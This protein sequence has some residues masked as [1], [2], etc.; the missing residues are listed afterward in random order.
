MPNRAV[1]NPYL[2]GT[3]PPRSPRGQPNPGRGFP[4]RGGQQGRRTGRAGFIAREGQ[5]VPTTRPSRGRG[6]PRSLIRGQ[7]SLFGQNINPSRRPSLAQ[8]TQSQEERDEIVRQQEIHREQQRQ[9][10]ISGLELLVAEANQTR[11]S[12]PCGDLDDDD[13]SAHESDDED[14]DEDKDG[15][16]VDD[17][18]DAPINNPVH[19]PYASNNE[20]LSRRKYQY[21]P[22]K[23]STLYNYLNQ[24]KRNLLKNI[25]E[26]AELE[27]REG[28]GILRCSIHLAKP[29]TQSKRIGTEQTIGSTCLLHSFSTRAPVVYRNFIAFIV[30][31][32]SGFTQKSTPSD[33]DFALTR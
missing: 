12:R 18:E 14:W 28:I 16:Y 30:V 33:L 29:A 6:R 31:R 2:R 20:K 19:N 11:I 25:H 5:Q 10:Q 17:D 4:V 15:M 21:R 22:P 13:D 24:K 27:K 26:R 32:K 7:G 9:Q 23:G 1:N 8:P 3:R